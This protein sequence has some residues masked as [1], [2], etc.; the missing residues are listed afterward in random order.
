MG[1]AVPYGL[2]SLAFVALLVLLHL[3]RRQQRELDVSSLLLWDAVHDEPPRGRFRPNPL[4]LLQLAAIVALAFAAA[5]PYWSERA[6]SVST[7]R[8]VL[9][10]DTS[11]SMQTVEGRERRFDQARRKAG[12]VLS[13]L[14]ADVEVMMIAVAAHPRVVVSFTRDRSSIA[15]ALESLEPGDGPTRLSLG[16]ELAHSLTNR[17]KSLDIDVFTDV[18]RDEVAFTPS[19]GERLRYFRFGQTDDNVAIAA[20]RV[21]Q[22]P[23]QDATEARGYALVRSYAN[24][25]KDVELHVTLGARPILDQTIHLGNRESRVVPID[26]LAEPGELEARLDVADALAVDNKAAAYVR[27]AR[28]IRLLAVSPSDEVLGDLRALARG[29]P[30]L[31]IHAAKPSEM[32]PLDLQ[33][34]EV[35]VFH[36]FVPDPPPALNALYVYPPRSNPLFPAG[37]EVSAAQ[38]LDWNDADPVL[39]DLRYLEALPLDRSRMVE[40]PEWA[41][42]LI[43]SRAEGKE[44]PLAFGGETGGRRVVCFAFDLA[45]RS[46]VKSENLSLLLLVLNSLRWLTPPDR[47]SPV[48]IDVGDDYREALA[49]PA[50]YRVTGPDGRTEDRPPTRQLAFEIARA[51]EYQVAIG[52]EERIVYANLFDADESDVGRKDGPGEEVIEGS[53]SAAPVVTAALLH[54]FGAMLVFG[55]VAL[56]VLE[57]IVWA[58]A[59]RRGADDVV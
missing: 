51:G 37:A 38:I 50:A 56:V 3:R 34:A 43:A 28:K 45:G 25:P 41:H 15:R 33:N 57:W 12:E 22:N 23:F 11:A 18:P 53:S 6:A 35:A 9:V 1:F 30:A 4:F 14:G 7:R 55:G 59:R 54:E 26:K 52:N 17:G 32:N 2:V 16:V 46:L 58:V 40:L 44:F 49:E 39:Q 20:L 47:R 21:Y 29:V 27:P 24:R 5:R 42:T 10:F 8:T 48:Q 31:D 19:S 13:D 36:D